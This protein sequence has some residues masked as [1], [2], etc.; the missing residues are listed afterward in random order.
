[1]AAAPYPWLRFYG[2]VPPTLDYPAA[3]LYEA[4]AATAARFPDAVAWDFLGTTSTYRRLIADIDRCATMLAALGLA[5]GERLLVS[6]P[7]SP[8][9]VIAFYAANKLGAVPAFIHPLSTAPEI[10]HYIDASGARIALALDAFYGTLAAA[11]P[12]R[13][14]ETILL[15]RIPD[16]LSVAKRFGFWLTK[17]RKIPSVPQDPRVR[18]WSD[19]MARN[20][21]E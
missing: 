9:A 3:T 7:T 18:W 13:P 20:Y 12:R 8:Q 6:L 15:A 1:M 11:A 17:G 4:L 5:H 10:A 16:Y 19:V 2:D 14:L 21:P